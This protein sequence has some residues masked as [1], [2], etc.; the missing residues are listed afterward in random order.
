MSYEYNSQGSLVE[1]DE[2]ERGV[3]IEVDTSEKVTSANGKRYQYN[4]DGFLV[5]RGP[6]RFRFNSKGRRNKEMLP[7]WSG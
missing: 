7:I 3:R 2:H 6:L 1:I 4:E 5:A